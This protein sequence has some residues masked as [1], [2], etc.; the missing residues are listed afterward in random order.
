MGVSRA[1]ETRDCG[2]GRSRRRDPPAACFSAK[3]AALRFDFLGELVALREREGVVVVVAH[4]KVT[5]L[6][7]R[8]GSLGAAG[9]HML[10]SI[11]STVTDSAV[12]V[13][14]GSMTRDPVP[15][16]ARVLGIARRSR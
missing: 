7:R 10:V 3:S 8:W 12:F 1:C 14:S 4:E 9:V 15:P 16:R 11:G 2:R 6:I 5:Q 13:S